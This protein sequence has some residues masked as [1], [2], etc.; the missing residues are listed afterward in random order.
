MAGLWNTGSG[1]VL[2]P[3]VLRYHHQ[4]LDLHGDGSWT[5]Q[6]ASEMQKGQNGP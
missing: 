3:A 6:A 4:V 1:R 5:L 2:R